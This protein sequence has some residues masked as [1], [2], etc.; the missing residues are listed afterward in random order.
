MQTNRF[1]NNQNLGNLIAAAGQQVNGSSRNTGQ[2]AF[3]LARTANSLQDLDDKA[4]DAARL[5]AARGKIDDVSTLADEIVGKSVTGQGPV[6]MIDPRVA[7]QQATVQSLPEIGLA[8]MAAQIDPKFNAHLAL[9]APF[10]EAIQR[11]IQ[12]SAGNSS[13]LN[14]NTAFTPQHQGEL[15]A[16]DD[17]QETALNDATVAGAFARQKYS[18]DSSAANARWLQQNAD[19][20]INA[21]QTLLPGNEARAD[22][23]GVE[24]GQP[25]QGL[26]T[27]STA[28]AAALGDGTSP[29][30]YF[31]GTGVPQQDSNLLLRGAAD[32]SFTATPQYSLAWNRTYNLPNHQV[33][34]EDGSIAF[35]YRTLDRLFPPP[36]GMA[37]IHGKPPGDFAALF[38]AQQPAAQ[39]G[40][41]APLSDPSVAVAGGAA[42]LAAAPGLAAQPSPEELAAL[43]SG[44]GAPVAGTAPK[45]TQ[46]ATRRLQFASSMF[47]A[48]PFLDSIGAG[49]DDYRPGIAYQIVA[50][51]NPK[52]AASS[53]LYRGLSERDKLL[54]QES[55]N[56]VD[57]LA[58]FRTGAAIKDEE[59]PY[60]MRTY[61][62]QPGDT[63]AILTAKRR[64]RHVMEQVFRRPNQD[65]RQLALDVQEI[66]ARDPELRQIRD[67]TSVPLDTGESRSFVTTQGGIQRVQ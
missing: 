16:Q 39:A 17:A 5:A 28:K 67:L 6:P 35:T 3:N 31:E 66:I 46:E 32:P 51:S 50:N 18:S 11:Q 15:R 25:V 21:G 19:A 9:A 12:L 54:H 64:R 33:T 14:L 60:Y 62:P 57:G 27:E 52:T 41:T 42:P 55:F 36:P 10:E 45:L 22:I 7:L 34:T 59:L 37:S 8:N 47:D 63:D 26:H 24:H 29:G 4:A 48:K 30:N 65:P 44:A 61:A 20:I 1:F 56:W 38:S 13:G 49:G 23:L 53:F 40:G 58:R 2:Y 43:A